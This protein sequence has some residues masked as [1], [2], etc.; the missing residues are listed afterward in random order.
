MLHVS[1]ARDG[2]II[3]PRSVIV[4]FFLA[5]EPSD[6]GRYGRR[7]EPSAPLGSACSIQSKK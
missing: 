3:S 6:R 7:V 2:T 1:D 5:A 4:G